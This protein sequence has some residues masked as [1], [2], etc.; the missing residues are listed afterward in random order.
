MHEE[1]L[2]RCEA[3][4]GGQREV[5][6]HRV[7]RD[8]CGHVGAHTIRDHSHERSRSTDD[9]SESASGGENRRHP[10]P[11]CETSDV[12]AEFPD[13]PGDLQAGD[14]TG[15]GWHRTGGP[16]GIDQAHSGNLHIDADLPRLR[17][18]LWDLGVFEAVKT[19]MPG[20]DES[21]HGFLLA[22]S[23]LLSTLMYI[24]ILM[25]NRTLL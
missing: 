18:W 1:A 2:A 6:S 24:R 19:I 10:L 23:D 20:D 17:T 21:M 4:D 3:G 12:L 25:K 5:G 13:G 8:H 9:L 11:E 15:E 7:D 22:G 16:E 14:E